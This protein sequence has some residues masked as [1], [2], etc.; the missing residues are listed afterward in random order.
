M[1]RAKL[2]K[3]LA[4]LI[5]IALLLLIGIFLLYVAWLPAVI[6]PNP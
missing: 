6:S 1:M 2:R 3:A 4:G 5:A